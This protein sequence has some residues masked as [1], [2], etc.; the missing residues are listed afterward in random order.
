MVLYVPS[1]INT[2]HAINKYA[3]FV[4]Y[5]KHKNTYR[6]NKIDKVSF[7]L[8]LPIVSLSSTSDNFETQCQQESDRTERIICLERCRT[9]MILIKIR[10]KHLLMI[11]MNGI[12]PSIIAST[13]RL[14]P[15]CFED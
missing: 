2:K 4:V 9:K 1:C 6:M 12:F 14:V 10:K 7:L 13:I 8:K 5:W 11:D 3:V 15:A